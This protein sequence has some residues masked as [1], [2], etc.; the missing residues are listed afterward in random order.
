[1]TQIWKL[2]KSPDQFRDLKYYRHALN[3][4]HPFADFVFDVNRELLNYAKYTS[5]SDSFL[6]F[7]IA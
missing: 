4:V 3:Y 5:I 2:L 7:N 6:G 1:M